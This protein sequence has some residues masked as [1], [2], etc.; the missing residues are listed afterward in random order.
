MK[1]TAAKA[2]ASAVVH[3]T[4]DMVIP[5]ALDKSVVDVVAQAMMA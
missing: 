2:L 3:P 1:L 4:E 5:N